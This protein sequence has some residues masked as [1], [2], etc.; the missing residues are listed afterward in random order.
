VTTRRTPEDDVAAPSEL[1]Y[2]DRKDAN[3]LIAAEPAALLIGIVLYQQVP[4]EKA[5]V[6]PLLLKERLGGSLDPSEI[7]T[8][9]PETLEEIFRQKP[10]LHRFPASMAKKVQAVCSYLVDHHDGEI[11][12][13]WSD[14]DTAQEVVRRIQAMPGFGEY[15]ARVYF[16]VLAERFA[17]RPEGWEALVPDW[18]SIADIAV[19]EDLSELKLRKKAWK[20]S[21]A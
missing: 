21:Q 8:T 15:K 2:T 9:D 4:T 13:L 19:P 6:G 10:A 11:A 1:H 16:G 20:E 3:E 14:A 17:V 7:A 5:F 18:P 12:D